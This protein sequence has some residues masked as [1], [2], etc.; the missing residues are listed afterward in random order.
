MKTSVYS[1][2]NVKVGQF[3]RPLNKDPEIVTSWY[4]VVRTTN[5]IVQTIQLAAEKQPEPVEVPYIITDYQCID[6]VRDVLMIP[7][8]SP[9]V[10]E[11][12]LPYLINGD[13]SGL[14]HAEYHHLEDWLRSY[15]SYNPVVY[16]L[17]HSYEVFSHSEEGVDGYQECIGAVM[18]QFARC[19]EVHVMLVFRSSSRPNILESEPDESGILTGEELWVQRELC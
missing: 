2:E 1:K 18:G 7:F 3:V 8:D 16:S 9:K 14:T 6:E 15:D 10:E 17:D 11:F 5:R 19:A 4:Q 13:V 12:F